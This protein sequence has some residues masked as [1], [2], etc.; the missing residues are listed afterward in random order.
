MRAAGGYVELV[1]KVLVFQFSLPSTRPTAAWSWS[2]KSSFSNPAFR[3]A[4]LP[5]ENGGRT[6]FPIRPV[7][8]TDWEIRPTGHKVDFQRADRRQRRVSIRRETPAAAILHRARWI[9]KVRNWPPSSS[10]FSGGGSQSAGSSQ[11]LNLLLPKLIAAPVP[12]GSHTSNGCEL[13]AEYPSPGSGTRPAAGRGGAG[14]RNV[15]LS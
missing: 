10:F 11:A 9:F 5:N 8:W 13:A 1:S 12:D 4:L 3:N 7:L 15:R 2:T 14:G 6:D